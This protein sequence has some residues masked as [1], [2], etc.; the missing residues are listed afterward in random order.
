MTETTITKTNEI[1]DRLDV[2]GRHFVEAQRV[3]KALSCSGVV[4]TMYQGNV[5]NCLIALDISNRVGVG[6]LAVMQKMYIVHGKPAFE[7]TFV[8]AAVNACG[9]YSPL[10]CRCN[11]LE[12]DN[13]GYYAVAV[14]LSTGEELR[15]TTV[16]W[17]MVK[18]EKWNQ[19]TKTK[20]GAIQKSKWN[21]LPE[22]MF[23]YRAMSFWQREFEPGL[24]MGIMTADETADVVA[25]DVLEVEPVT[26]LDAVAEQNEKKTV[27]ESPARTET[28]AAA[29]ELWG[30]NAMV[31]LS[32]E[33]RRRNKS[34]TDATDTDFAAVLD[35]INEALEERKGMGE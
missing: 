21:T 6:V 19:D 29:R 35:E 1:P 9:R 31:K 28:M 3:A 24:T 25:H 10:R 20:S 33:L 26:T 13:F 22:Q 32:Q 30:D 11:N 34:I 8:A 7:A 16:D 23:K 12:G 17:K 27:A 5:P 14:E 18:A 15:G 4:P 2:F